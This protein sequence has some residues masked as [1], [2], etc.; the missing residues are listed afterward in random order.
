M[1]VLQTDNKIILTSTLEAG[2]KIGLGRLNTDGSLDNTFGTNGI[3]TTPPLTNNNPYALIHNAILQPDNKLLAMGSLSEFGSNYRLMIARF[4]TQAVATI[5][6]PNT[7]SGISVAPN[8]VDAT[9]QFCYTL[10]D[11]AVI[12]IRLYDVLGREIHE[13]ASNTRQKAGKYTETLTMP[14][15]LPQGAY[16]IT[17]HT[18][19]NSKSVRVVKW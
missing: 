1:T 11:E 10:T 18:D 16:I 15:N 4:N 12:S 5:N 14:S 8:P 9:T 19:G 2:T 6:E 17:I 13:F 7:L 3:S